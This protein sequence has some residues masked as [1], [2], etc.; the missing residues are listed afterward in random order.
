MVKLN[1]W[2]ENKTYLKCVSKNCPFIFI[3]DIKLESLN[4]NEIKDVQIKFRNLDQCPK[5]KYTS[6]F[7][8]VIKGKKIGESIYI[9]FTVN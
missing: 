9:Y 8:V 4:T 5:G 7:D 6:V 2:I 3:D 1:K